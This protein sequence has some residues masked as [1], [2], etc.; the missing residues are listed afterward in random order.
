[1]KIRLCVVK[2]GKYL[3]FKEQS[4]S[5]MWVLI[6][7]TG[8]IFGSCIRD[9]GFNIHL[10]QNWLVFWFDNKVLLSKTDVGSWNSQKKKKKKK[11]Y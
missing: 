8:K 6:S 10:H 11:V 7:S 3:L 9:L 1:M 5:S 4:T 2:W